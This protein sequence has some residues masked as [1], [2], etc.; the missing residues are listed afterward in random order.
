MMP[1]PALSGCSKGIIECAPSPP[2]SARARS[3][4]KVLVARLLAERTES[5]AARAKAS[6]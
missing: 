4:W 6:G 1:K 3:P 2:N 5:Q